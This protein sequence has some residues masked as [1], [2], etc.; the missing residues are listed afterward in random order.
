MR[1]ESHNEVR[2]SW[3]ESQVERA[4]PFGA[5]ATAAA[6]ASTGVNADY[7]SDPGVADDVTLPEGVLGS[8]GEA[9]DQQQRSAGTSPAVAWASPEEEGGQLVAARRSSNVGGEVTDEEVERLRRRM[10]KVESRIYQR[11]ADERMWQ[12]QVCLYISYRAAVC[13]APIDDRITLKHDDRV[14]FRHCCLSL[15]YA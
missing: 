14:F 9:S 6:A 3:L 15:R 4:P 10:E 8:D 7:D 2:L 13:I 12:S 1:I 11:C 5:P